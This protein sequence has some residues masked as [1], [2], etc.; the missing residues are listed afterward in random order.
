MKHKPILFQEILKKPEKPKKE[1][2]KKLKRLAKT[3]RR[4]T[5]GIFV[6]IIGSILLTVAFT[7]LMQRR[8]FLD[9]LNEII[10]AI[11]DRF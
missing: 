1:K 4:Y 2:D 11:L 6:S 10:R 3:A 5:L 8:P 9:V 7:S